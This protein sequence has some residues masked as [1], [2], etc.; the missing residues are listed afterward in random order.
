MDY[1]PKTTEQNPAPITY[2]LKKD[3]TGKPAPK[4]GTQLLSNHKGHKM[5]VPFPPKANCKKCN[6]RGYVGTDTKTG[7]ML[8]CRKCYPHAP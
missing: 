6:G 1:T 2:E 7:A 4:R 5:K 3:V 8:I